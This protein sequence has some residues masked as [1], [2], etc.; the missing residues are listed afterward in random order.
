MNGRF[1]GRASI[2]LA[3]ANRLNIATKSSPDARFGLDSITHAGRRLNMNLLSP[4]TERPQDPNLD[5]Q[6][7][8]FE[9]LEHGGAEPDTMPQAIKGVDAQGRSR[10]YVIS[11]L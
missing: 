6:G 3:Y 5:G 7:W 9:T 2:G 1:L 4:S 10:I 8:A 11:E